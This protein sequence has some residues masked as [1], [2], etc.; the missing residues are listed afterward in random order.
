M[1]AYILQD[2]DFR[3][4]LLSIKQDASRSKTLSP[5]EQQAVDDTFRFFNYHVVNWIQRQG[6]ADVTVEG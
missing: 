5:L 1:K 6:A 3:E 4:L 2:S